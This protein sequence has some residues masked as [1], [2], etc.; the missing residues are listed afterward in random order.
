MLSIRNSRLLVLILGLV[1]LGCAQVVAPSGGEKDIV[2]PQMLESNP[3]HEQK[4][5][6]G[7]KIRFTFSEF[8]KLVGFKDELLV[9]PPLKHSIITKMRAKTLELNI[10]D[11]LKPNTTY[12]FNFGKGVV[13]ITEN[14]PVENFVYVFSTGDQIDTLSVKGKVKD[15]F[16]SEVVKGAV[17]M[18]Y[19]QYEDSIPYLSLPNYIARTDEEGVYK[20]TNVKAGKYKSFALIDANNNFMLD[21]SDKI[22][23]FDTN[24][25]TV[26]SNVIDLNFSLFE[27]DNSKQYV[28]KQNEKGSVITLVFNR[29]FDSLQFDFLDTNRNDVLKNFYEGVNK[30]SLV[31][32]F[33][34]MNKQKL[35]F[36]IQAD[37]SFRD[38]ITLKIDS[39]AEKF[40]TE[41]P[42]N[43]PF[44][45][46][47]VIKNNFPIDSLSSDSVNI[48]SLSDSTFIS[49][50]LQHDSLSKNFIVNAELLEGEN[51]KIRILPNTV[52]DIY[53]RTNDTIFKRFSVTTARS[54]GN[55][56][57]NVE[58]SIE[59]PL[60]VQ[61]LDQKGK[62]QREQFLISEGKLD[63]LYL[64]AGEYKIRLIVDSNNDQ[65]W[66]TGDYL[67]NR[68]PERVVYYQESITIRSNWDQDINWK[69]DWD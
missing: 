56:Y 36:D 8:V 53:G 27:E 49:F 11:T 5:F 42:S 69:I 23:G 22:L 51:Y 6:D 21:K 55:L 31:L 9:S 47:F 35:K 39:I 44:F 14:N 19:D 32:Y 10:K 60:I 15:A 62:V 67:G 68:Y 2:A 54:Y 24:L 38:T 48:M 50:N 46:P 12:I 28:K 63:F 59:E 25:V 30:D 64:T 52:H 57:L 58:Q 26:D 1:S 17:V 65:I 40:K 13:D 37:T 18:L 61:L 29:S 34:E 16:T 20:I 41:V 66:T 45:K 33:N 3:P 43:Q 4:N 7:N